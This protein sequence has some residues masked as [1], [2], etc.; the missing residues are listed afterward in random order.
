MQN[1]FNINDSYF[2]VTCDISTVFLT[3]WLYKGLFEFK[4]IPKKYPKTKK[5]VPFRQCETIMI[6]IT[7]FIYTCVRAR[8]WNTVRFNMDLFNTFSKRHGWI[9]CHCI[10]LTPIHTHWTRCPLHSSPMV[11]INELGLGRCLTLRSTSRQAAAH[12]VG[13][14]PQMTIPRSAGDSCRLPLDKALCSLC[15]GCDLGI[16]PSCVT[17]TKH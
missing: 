14:D 11:L 12:H 3:L 1:I 16:L 13:G 5:Y 9:K 6:I 17:T 7:C 4:S 10:T 15:Q 8:D 2:I